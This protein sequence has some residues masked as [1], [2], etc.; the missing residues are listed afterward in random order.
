M[1]TL[2]FQGSVNNQSMSAQE[3]V[4]GDGTRF[5]VADTANNRVL[6]WN[7]IPS[8]TNQAANIVLG[9]ANMTTVSGS[10]ATMPKISLGL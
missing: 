4:S 1:T 6:I 5:F 2:G 7:S 8:T 10:T 9:Q 3:S